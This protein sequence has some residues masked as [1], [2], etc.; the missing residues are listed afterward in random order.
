MGAFALKRFGKGLLIVWFIWS[1]V[2]VLVRITGDPVEW[3]LPDGAKP[4][5]EQNLREALHLDEPIH[6]QYISSLEDLF[7]GDWGKSYYY[8]RP[9]IDLYRERIGAT[10]RLALPALLIADIL[11]VILGM[12]AACNRDSA[13]DRFTMSFTLIGS[14][15]PSFILGILLIF[16]FAVQ[17]RM[18]PTGSTGTWKHYIL[19][20]VSMMVS[21]MASVGRLTRSALLD[22]LGQEYLDG[23]R[24]KG[25]GSL[26]VLF[27]HALRNS[28]IPVI[29]S[30]GMQLGHVLGGAVTI[31]AVFGWPGVG[32]LISTAAK[33]RDFPT[34]QFGVTVVAAAVTLVTIL[35]DI[36]YGLLDPRIRANYK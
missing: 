11:G 3:I 15:M 17:L 24:M 25:V 31:E 35:I 36:S 18:L 22:N 6:Q 10:L 16:L 2:F 7:H 34:I 33:Q 27:R 19:P 29:T 32:S 14:S 1:L 12:I 28:L 26:A 30:I 21:P 5:D 23:V 9:V 8:K 13:I 4:E 20:A